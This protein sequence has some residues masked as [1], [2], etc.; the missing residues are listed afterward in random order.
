M[1]RFAIY[2][3]PPITLDLLTTRPDYSLIHQSHKSRMREEPLN[4]DGFG[5][6][7][8]VPDISTQPAQYRSVRPA[9]NNVNLL[10]LARV[11]RSGVIMAHVRAATAG[12]GVTESNCHPFA[13]GPYAFMHN[14]SVGEFQKLKRPLRRE[15]TDET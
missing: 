5:L 11:S 14:G 15:L 4:G 13:C 1:C 10:H 8:Y 6:S 7:W 12:F 3:G 2:M 9:W